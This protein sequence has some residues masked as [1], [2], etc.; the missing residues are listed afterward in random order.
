MRKFSQINE[1]KIN[2]SELESVLDESGFDYEIINDYYYTNKAFDKDIQSLSKESKYSK[3]IVIR[4]DIR[5]G[6]LNIGGWDKKPMNF[7]S[8]GFDPFDDLEDAQNKY[9]KIFEI[10]KR[11]KSNSPKLIFK[12]NKFIITILGENIS[13]SDL[14]L[15]DETIKVKYQLYKDLLN[16]RN[17]MNKP[18]FTVAYW[19]QLNSLHLN[20]KEYRK[21]IYGDDFKNWEK[22]WERVV[23]T[24]EIQKSNLP[25]REWMKDVEDIEGLDDIRDSVNEKGFYINLIPSN[26]TG[27]FKI[28]LEEF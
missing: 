1:N 15:K 26:D 12:D 20:L 10:V 2:E 9:N 19:G 27:K 23:K 14:E 4:P 8:S 28:E 3:V 17:S 24:L 22:T 11:L 6:Y 7:N 25:G 13:P 21:D 18:Y 16:F 5:K